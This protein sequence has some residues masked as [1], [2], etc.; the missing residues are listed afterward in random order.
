MSKSSRE[1][2]GRWPASFAY[3]LALAVLSAWTLLATPLSPS[4]PGAVPNPD[5]LIKAGHWKRARATLDELC[6]ADSGGARCAY[7]RSQVKDAFGDLD[8]ALP[9]AEKAVQLD[10]GN[11]AYHYQLAQVCGETAENAS[12]FKAAAWA[13]RFKAEAEQAA[14][15]DS[16]NTDA[17]FALIE[18]YLQAPRLIG[19]SK[20]KAAA[21][22]REIAKIDPA[23]GYLAEARLAED[24]KDTAAEEQS[25]RK[26]VAANPRDYDALVALAA[27]CARDSVKKYGEAAK[28]ARQALEVDLGRVEAYSALSTASAAREDWSSLDSALAEAARNVSDDFSPYY[29]AGRVLLENGQNLPRAERYFRKYLTQ[30]PEGGA[31]SLAQAHWRLGLT[32]GKEGRKADAVSELQTAVRL[33]P[34]LQEAK[35]DLDRL[36]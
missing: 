14:S 8:A 17:R 11:A 32:L 25:Y 34:D 31:P 27:F 7:W 16:R 28:Y 13:K 4:A 19:G 22:A 18:Y 1:P 26:A 3:P 33:K 10:G 21:M 29:Q 12:F 9:L 24:R 35:K 20:D 5:A 30:E 6:R 36:K 23:Q 15:L 2:R